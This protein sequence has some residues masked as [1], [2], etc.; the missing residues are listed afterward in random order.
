MM[1]CAASAMVCRPLEQKRFT[2]M[3]LTV[4]RQAGAQR[5]LARDVAAGGAL[6]Q[7]A[8]HEHVVD[9]ARVD[10]G[11]LDGGFHRMAAQLGAVR[12]VEGALKLLPSG[13]RAVETMTARVMMVLP[14]RRG[15]G[16]VAFVRRRL[17]V[18]ATVKPPGRCSR[19]P[20]GQAARSPAAAGPR[21]R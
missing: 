1:R 14:C 17:G 20:C 8:A 5:D 4:D 7:R 18:D 12:H 21:L 2:V 6:G 15:S 3:P 11:A 13:V 9:R 10:A 16:G 19:P